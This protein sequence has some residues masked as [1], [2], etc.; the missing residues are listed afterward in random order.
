MFCTFTCNLHEKFAVSL[1]RKMV[2]QKLF[3]CLQRVDNK[4]D[5]YNKYCI[6]NKKEQYRLRNSQQSTDVHN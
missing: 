6:T 1:L 3:F 2:R 5:L 4:L